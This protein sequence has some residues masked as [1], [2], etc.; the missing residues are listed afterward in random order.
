MPAKQGTN[1]VERGLGEYIWSIFTVTVGIK[2][3][4]RECQMILLDRLTEPHTFILVVPHSL[5]F[6][7]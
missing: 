3:D 1:G 6:F 7:A 5:E 2:L 4:S